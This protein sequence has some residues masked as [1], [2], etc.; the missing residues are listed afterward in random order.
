MF[1]FVSKRFKTIKI[2]DLDIFSLF[3]FV[4][5]VLL[6]NLYV[7]MFRNTRYGAWNFHLFMFQFV[8]KRF[9]TIK[10]LDLDI[11]SLFHFVSVV[12]LYNLYVSMFRNTR[13]GASN[14][15]LFLF[16]FVSKGFETI[17]SV[18]LE[19]FCLFHFVSVVL[20]YNLYVSMFR[21]TRYGG[22]NFHLF[23]FQ[24]VSKR[25]ETI[26]SVDLEI[27]CLFQFVSVVLLYNIYVSMFR[28]TRYGAWNFH[29]FMFQFVSKRFETIES[30]DLEIFSLFQFVS[31]SLLY[32]L[33]V[34]MFRNT[35]YGGWN[36]HL[37]MFQFVSK[38]F[39]TIESVDLEIFSL[40]QFV[41]VSLLYNLYVSMFRNTRYGVWNFHL[42]TFQFV[43]KRFETIES[44]DL[45]IFSLFQFVSVSL[46]YN[47]YV[48]MFRNTR[49]GGWNFHLFFVSVCFETFR[50]N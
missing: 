9:E 18:D 17:E 39:E 35:R 16:Q 37:F 6:Y 5:V 13:Y 45:D 44:V 19:I 28:N 27:F 46:L 34:S 29:L 24:F 1:Q 43:S 23:L 48:S 36:F 25:F 49:Y 11:F 38:R 41:S 42:F 50:N 2:L 8:S 12:L 20:L 30:V 15:H 10:I 22:W 33:Y 7:S 32:N 26:E 3:R 40:F 31:V 47:L 4:S 21:N 14:F